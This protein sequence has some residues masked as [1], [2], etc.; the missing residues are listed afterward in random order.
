MNVNQ[1]AVNIGLAGFKWTGKEVP[2]QELIPNETYY[3]LIAFNENAG[4]IVLFSVGN[5]PASSNDGF[6]GQFDFSHVI[7]EPFGIQ[8]L[9]D[10]G[11]SDWHMPSVVSDWNKQFVGVVKADTSLNGLIIF[12]Y[13]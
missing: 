5:Y 13:C 11:L 10:P 8:Y 9:T 7:R 3:C 12:D 4:Q 6:G 1:N 2:D